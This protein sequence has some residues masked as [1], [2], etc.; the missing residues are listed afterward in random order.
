[1]AT[2]ATDAN[3]ST[4]PWLQS[5]AS[6]AS[7]TEK[8]T[9][10]ASY[11]G[12]DAFLQLLIT[13]LQNQDPTDPMKDRE[14]ISQMA[15]FSSLEQMQNMNTGFTALQN[16][17]TNTLMP[18]MLMQQASSLIGQQV[19]YPGTDEEGNAVTLSGTVDKVVVSEGKPYCVINGKNIDPSTFTEIGAVSNNQIDELIDKLDDLM[20]IL[21][22]EEGAEDDI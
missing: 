12:K 11:L 4:V 16:T 10:A 19:S 21:V 6:T 18:N 8:S 13:E 1:M 9:N 22:P 5:A 20:N 7:K 17:I 3:Y 15:S 2:T 14:F